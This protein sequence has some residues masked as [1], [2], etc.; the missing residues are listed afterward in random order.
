MRYL[1]GFLILLL[2]EI[3]SAEANHLGVG[4]WLGIF[5]EQTTVEI[6]N[7]L[8]DGQDLTVHCKS[9]DD[10]LGLQVLKQHQ[11]YQF[12]FVPSIWGNTLFFCSFRWA[13]NFHYFDVYIGHRD[14]SRC[15]KL[16]SWNIHSEGP[17]GVSGTHPGLSACLPWNEY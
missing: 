12:R 1:L 15:I 10:D 9:K 5:E 17:C 8:P 4:K 16:C 14:G 6:K 11:T 13:E 7:E 3:S 2:V